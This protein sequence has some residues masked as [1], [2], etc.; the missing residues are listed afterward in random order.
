MT[1]M[2]RARPGASASS[3]QLP[4]RAKQK[5]IKQPMA[6]V[7]G[8]AA[9]CRCS[10][11][12]LPPRFPLVVLVAMLTVVLVAA[13]SARAAWVEDYPSG[14][15]CGATIPVEQCDPG[16]AAA[17]SACMD[18]CHYGGCRRGGRCV[19]LGFARGRGCHCR[20]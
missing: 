5:L 18:V 13:P 15:P 17:N 6:R 16:D 19:S 20:C 2:H 9:A 3:R 1:G 11:P 7:G 14:V 12:L 4:R 10:L 8:D